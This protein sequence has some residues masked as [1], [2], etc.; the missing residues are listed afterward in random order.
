MNYAGTL[1]SQQFPDI[2]IQPTT[3]IA[4]G[5]AGALV[6]TPEG[7]FVQPVHVNQNHWVCISNI[8]CQEGTVKIYDSMSP[9]ELGKLMNLHFYT[10]L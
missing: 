3:V 2:I 5:S 4:A 8:N 7:K 6:G 1:L 9:S 10:K